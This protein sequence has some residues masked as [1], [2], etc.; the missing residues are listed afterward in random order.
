[1]FLY[2]HVRNLIEYKTDGNNKN[3]RIMLSQDGQNFFLKLQDVFPSEINFL[4]IFG[5]RLIEDK[6]ISIITEVIPN[7]YWKQNVEINN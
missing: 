7:S 5:S 2:L 3:P 6:T 4:E 1:M